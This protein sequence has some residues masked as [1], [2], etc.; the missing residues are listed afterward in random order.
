MISTSHFQ[1]ML[2]SLQLLY[3]DANLNNQS[4]TIVIIA[5]FVTLK[6]FATYQTEKIHFYY[7]RT[8]KKMQDFLNKTNVRE[9]TYTPHWITLNGVI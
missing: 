3:E 7:N 5:L 9:M 1:S 2:G 8:S 4:Y 6:V